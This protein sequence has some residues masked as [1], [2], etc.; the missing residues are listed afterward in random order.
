MAGQMALIGKTNGR[1]YFRKRHVSLTQE[2]FGTLNATLNDILI[3]GDPCGLFEQAREVGATECHHLGK[4]RK[5]D[6]LIKS[7]VDIVSDF[8]DLALGEGPFWQGVDDW[9]C[10]GGS[11][12]MKDQR[13]G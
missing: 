3:R 9:K 2:D 5:A 4:F 12:Q 1:R 7:I 10:G 11:K 6:A 8:G 13:I